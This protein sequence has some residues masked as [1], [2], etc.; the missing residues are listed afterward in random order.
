ML[1][2]FIVYFL[3]ILSCLAGMSSKNERAL[4]I[5]IVILALFAGFRYYVGVDY[6]GYVEQ[7]YKAVGSEN[8]EI[9]FDFVTDLLIAIGAKP[10]SLF[11]VWAI[12]MQAMV[13]KY[14]RRYNYNV[15]LSLMIYFCVST[16]YIA[17]FNGIRQY[18]AIAAFMLSFS[19][20]M[21][22]KFL[23]YCLIYVIAVL[24][25]HESILAFFPLYFILHK[26][27][28]IWIKVALFAGAL[29]V[30]K[31]IDLILTYTPY[32]AYTTKERETELSIFTYIFLAISLLLT[33]LEPLIKDFKDK[34]LFF[35]INYI[36]LLL[37]L[38]VIIQ[39][40]GIMKQIILR[41]NSYVLFSYIVFL[42]ALIKQIKGKQVRMLAYIGLNIGI[43][44]YLIRTVAFH[45]QEYM[46][47]PYRMSFELF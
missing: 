31:S 4:V 17:T 44:L 45:G 22:R 33:L 29:V 42:P 36:N 9:G 13:Y 32:L 19:S 8:R 6:G 23:C 40:E 35:N 39:S 10:Q 34:R 27:W 20:I 25:F 1:P 28:S 26:K 43:L 5:P 18:L 21:E 2:Y 11:L 12:V 47:V 7:F 38:L 46:L 41:M 16:F 3:L 30:N 15:W 14:F 24:F 37:L